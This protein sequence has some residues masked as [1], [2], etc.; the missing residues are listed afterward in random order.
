MLMNWRKGEPIPSYGAAEAELAAIADAVKDVGRGW[1]QFVGDYGDAIDE[2]FG[3]LKRMAARSGRPL[4][5]TN[6]LDEVDAILFA[7]HPGT[8]GGPAIAELLFGVESPSGKLPVT[9]PR[10]VGQIP[11]YY[12]HKN[13]GRPANDES[14]VLIDDIPVEAWQS[15]LGNTSH[16]LDLG[17]R[18]RFPFGY[19]LTYSTFR[20]EDLKVEPAEIPLGGSVEVSDELVGHVDETK[21]ADSPLPPAFPMARIRSVDR[22]G[23]V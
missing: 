10:M 5:L 21:V 17:R 4:T 6:I 7:W 14:M 15:S 16:Y 19:G 20:Y 3:L 8:M 2:E 22:V 23:F 13:T 18:P 12:N 1:L 9:F 11:I